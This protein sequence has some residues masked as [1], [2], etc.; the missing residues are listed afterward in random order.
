MYCQKFYSFLFLF[1]GD[2]KNEKNLV[3]KTL[4]VFWGDEPI[5]DSAFFEWDS[6]G[7]RFMRSIVFEAVF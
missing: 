7:N 3:F 4:K 2:K 6:R 1:I 5:M